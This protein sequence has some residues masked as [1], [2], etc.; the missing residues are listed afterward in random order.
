VDG[1]NTGQTICGSVILGSGEAAVAVVPEPATLMLFGTTAASLGL[2]RW[3]QRK[4]K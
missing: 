4:R 1:C 2:A 3:R